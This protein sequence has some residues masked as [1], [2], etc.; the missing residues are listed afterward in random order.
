MLVR[1]WNKGNSHIVIGKIYQYGYYVKQ[2]KDFFKNKN[3]NTTSSNSSTS[4]YLSE[5]YKANSK[6]K[7][8]NKQTNKTKNTSLK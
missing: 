6:K 8:T 5:D 3:R 4:G 7:K 1:M 2:H